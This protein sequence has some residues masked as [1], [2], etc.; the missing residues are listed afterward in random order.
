MSTPYYQDD[1]V[2]LYHGDCR[3][4]LPTLENVDHVITDPPYSDT[5]HEGAD[6]LTQTYRLCHF[7]AYLINLDADAPT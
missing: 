5:T 3:D 1:A 7:F 2:T 4:V 6:R